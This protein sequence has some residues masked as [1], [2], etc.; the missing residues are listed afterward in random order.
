MKDPY[1]EM[2]PAVVELLDSLMGETIPNV[3]VEELYEEE[4][5][6]IYL[7]LSECPIFEFVSISN[8]IMIDGEPVD[9]VIEPYEDHWFGNDV[10]LA[11][12]NKREP[13]D[14]EFGYVVD[15]EF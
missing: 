1:S 5:Y 4:D 10:V 2:R 6:E 13:E 9:E 8:S 7:L 14:M 3:T 11:D 12:L 15:W